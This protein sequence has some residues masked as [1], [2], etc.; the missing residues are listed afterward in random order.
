MYEGNNMRT[1]KCLF[2]YQVPYVTNLMADAV[3]LILN[4]CFLFSDRNL[5]T[6][7]LDALKFILG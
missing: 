5:E 6:N 4:Y 7:N 2:V 1:A 3:V